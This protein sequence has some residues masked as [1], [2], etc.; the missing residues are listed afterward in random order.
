MKNLLIVNIDEN[1]KEAS[2]LI[3]K[4]RENLFILY[5]NNNIINKDIEHELLDELFLPEYASEIYDFTRNF[6]KT[7]HKSIESELK[8]FDLS[9]PNLTQQDILKLWPILLKI[10]ILTKFFKNNNFDNIHVVTEYEEDI[11]II[12]EIFKNKI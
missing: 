8:Y 6:S 7:W 10:K 12:N 1:I 3:N 5:L 11:R 4:N 2:Y 9:L